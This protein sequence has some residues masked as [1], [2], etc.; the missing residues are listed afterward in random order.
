MKYVV[1]VLSNLMILQENIVVYI[2]AVRMS[3][4]STTTV[5]L[6]IEKL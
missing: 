1:R 3:L 2:Q 6:N 4:G 5:F